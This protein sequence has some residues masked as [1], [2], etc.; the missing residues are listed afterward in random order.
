MRVD[1][2]FLS[3]MV[4]DTARNR[5]MRLVL[6]PPS[7]WRQSDYEVGSGKGKVKVLIEACRIAHLLFTSAIGGVEA[8]G[9]HHYP[10]R[11]ILVVSHSLSSTTYLHQ[12]SCQEDPKCVKTKYWKAFLFFTIFLPH[13]VKK[14][15][16]IQHFPGEN[17]VVLGT[18]L[19]SN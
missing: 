18:L 2:R 9:E 19:W 11:S 3:F 7:G 10:E 4:S 8:T 14:F 13:I 1:L 16:L 12:Y 5:T 17:V 15:I 6:R